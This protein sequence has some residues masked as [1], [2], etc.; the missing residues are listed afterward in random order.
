MKRCFFLYLIVFYFFSSCSSDTYDIIV[1][2]ASDPDFINIENVV[3]S[4]DSRNYPYLTEKSEKEWLILF[5]ID[6]D[7][8]KN[9][10]LFQEMAQICKGLRNIYRYDGITPKK[11]YNNVTAVGL[12]DGFNKDTKYTPNYYMPLS[13]LFEFQYP[14]QENIT[15]ILSTYKGTP[16]KLNFLKD[17]SNDVINDPDDNWLGSYHEV[18]MADK[19]TLDKFLK[20]ALKK[21]NND[22][23][24]RV[25]IVMSGEGGGSFGKETGSY[26]PSSRAI[27][28]DMSSDSYYLSMKD[29]HDALENNNFTESNKL[30]LLVMEQDY[31]ASLEDLYEIK[32]VVKATLASPSS[33]PGSSVDM[34]YFIQSLRKNSTIY[35]I[36]TEAV[37]VF[38]NKNYTKYPETS[39]GD[40][41]DKNQGMATLTFIDMS[42]IKELGDKVNKL[43]DGIYK[44]NIHNENYLVDQ[45]YT[46]LE[47][48]DNKE[49]ISYE[50]GLL[51]PD[52]YA[53]N[54]ITDYAMFYKSWYRHK[55]DRYDYF[56]GHFYMFDLGY[57]CE[58]S[59][60][61]AS[62]A[63]R[64]GILEIIEPADNIRQFLEE[65]IISSWRNGT[66]SKSGIYTTL[67][68]SNIYGI[69]IT[70][71]AKVN[72]GS[73]KLY[74]QPYN[75]ST[76]TYKDYKKDGMH[77]WY[78]V[79][80]TLYEEQFHEN[81]YLED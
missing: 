60:T 37:N 57:F 35:S 11:E 51:K 21:Y 55:I 25:I 26:V 18:N 31:S 6:A 79:L 29:V 3:S 32:D 76:F 58:K 5:Y 1:N 50:Y 61:V 73:K 36:G 68:N 34:N 52:D 71:P 62:K 77:N 10:Q 4:R 16:E 28:R 42:K 41:P 69:T 22:N 14:Q 20:W 12:W 56:W 66:N 63:G 9:D 15:Q 17:V 80:H 43:A 39:Y 13:Y 23:S 53:K 81:P 30:D 74:M 48:M 65:T 47:C 64:D 54:F 8:Y 59:Y 75:F 24:K 46:F 70:G 7:N 78:D 67:S 72:N 19:N 44:T 40:I 2:C 38:A 49:N 27:N 45:K 33:L